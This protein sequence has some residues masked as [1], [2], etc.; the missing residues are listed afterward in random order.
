MKPITLHPLSVL[1][2]L[3]LA[4][5]LLVLASAAQS[6]GRLQSIPTHDVRVVGVI[7]AEWWTYID[8]SGASQ[9]YTV[10]FDRYLVVTSHYLYSG[11]GVV[12][13]DGQPTKLEAVNYQGSSDRNGT[14]IAFPPGTVLT[15]SIPGGATIWGY[16]EPV[17]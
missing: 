15:L 11:G 1:A 9:T 10:P 17:N 6:P 2:G 3:V 5:A 12:L 4:G 16:L 8:L 14:R 7:P 13:A